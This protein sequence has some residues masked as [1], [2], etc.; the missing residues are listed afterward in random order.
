MLNVT[1]AHTARQRTLR[2]GSPSILRTWKRRLTQL[3]LA[4][5]AFGLVNL[6]GA[7]ALRAVPDV[8]LPKSTAAAKALSQ[9]PALVWTIDANGD[10]IADFSN[11]THR[12]VRGVDAFG[13]GDFL[14]RRDGGARK[15]HGVDYIAAVGQSVRAPISGE[16]SRLGYAYGGDGGYR[17]IEIANSETK[18]TARVLYVA[19]SVQVGDVVVAGQEIGVAQDLSKRYPGITNHVHV[20]LREGHRLLDAT[21]QLPSTALW[22]QRTDASRGAL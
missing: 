18:H 16:V 8:S 7:D 19:P 13:S 21:E 1:H 2:L 22:A 10:G 15:H 5:A 17:V 11:P 12:L 9:A 20:E 4:V 3:G 14:A 6:G